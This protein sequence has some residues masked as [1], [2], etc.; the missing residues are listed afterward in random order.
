MKSYVVGPIRALLVLCLA[1]SALLATPQIPRAHASQTVN[2]TK[3]KS[4]SPQISARSILA[5]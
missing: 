1:L 3:P 5:R 4:S 2:L